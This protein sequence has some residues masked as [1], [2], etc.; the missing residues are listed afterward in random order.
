MIEAVVFDLDG[1][2]ID[3]EPVWEQVRRRVVAEHGGHWDPD[4]Q[5]RLMGMST[6]EWS[7][8]LSEDL[9][10][11]L[12]PDQGAE[13]VID[14]FDRGVDKVRQLPHLSSDGSQGCETGVVGVTPVPVEGLAVEL[15]PRDEHL[16]FPA[17]TPPV[18]R[19]RRSGARPRPRGRH[20]V[21]LR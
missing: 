17:R 4:T 14:L 11:A 18:L 1:V 20:Q 16:A 9:D 7:R 2:L 8:Y 12:S 3:S 15:S 5:D 13:T 6:G 19:Y 10:V 21:V